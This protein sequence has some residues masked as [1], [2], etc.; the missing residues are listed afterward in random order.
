M[1]VLGIETSCD[2]TAVALV[3]DGRE[4]LSSQISSSLE[5]HRQYGGI[6]PEAASRYHLEFIL[7]I[8]DGCLKRAKLKFK[9][10]D[11]I[12]V[13]CG[14]GLIG[15]L[16]IGIN[17]AKTISFSLQKPLIEINHLHAHLYAGFMQTNGPRL[18]CVG[19]VV[20][21]GHTELFYIR[22]FSDF[23]HLGATRDDAC[24]EVFDK[25]AKILK[26]SFPGGPIIDKLA[27]EG[28]PHRIKFSCASFKDSLDF[29]FSGI[30]TAVLYYV[31]KNTA[32]AKPLT[33]EET[34][35]ICASFQ[36]SLI[37]VLIRNSLRACKM[38]GTNQLVLGGGVAAN[39]RLR[40]KLNQ[41]A[42]K[43]GV[44]VFIPESN[45]CL[46]NACMV[47]GLGYNLYK[48]R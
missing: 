33:L 19:L 12:S 7:P 40:E 22:S 35:D 2:E 30:K 15:S 4:I 20:S 26:L 1:I 6:I 18:P 42:E 25:V 38:K 37:N 10:I 27:R 13:T 21:G 43:E 23:E 29:S 24:G 41:R 34:K 39:S 16:L 9:D 28:N 32:D 17:F 48:E 31:K 8:L 14:P 36:E 3:K 45:L 47:A 11:L 44:D 46:D 5:F